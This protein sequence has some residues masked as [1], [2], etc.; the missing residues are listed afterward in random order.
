MNFP[1]DDRERNFSM[2]NFHLSYLFNGIFKHIYK[3]GERLEVSR[4]RRHGFNGWKNVKMPLWTGLTGANLWNLWHRTMISTDLRSLSLPLPS[5]FEVVDNCERTEKRCTTDFESKFHWNKRVLT[6]KKIQKLLHWQRTNQQNLSCLKASLFFGF[7]S[8]I[9][10]RKWKTVRPNKKRRSKVEIHRL[11][12]IRCN[13]KASKRS[14]NDYSSSLK[15]FLIDEFPQKNV[16]LRSDETRTH[17]FFHDLCP[18]SR[19]DWA[20]WRWR[21]FLQANSINS[22]CFELDWIWNWSRKPVEN[23]SRIFANSKSQFRFSVV[24]IS[25]FQ[26]DSQFVRFGFFIMRSTKEKL[27][28]KE[29]EHLPSTNRH[30]FHWRNSNKK[31]NEWNQADSKDAETWSQCRWAFPSF[32][33]EEICHF[34]SHFNFSRFRWT[35]LLLYQNKSKREF[36][37]QSRKRSILLPWREEMQRHWRSKTSNKEQFVIDFAYSGIFRLKIDESRV[38]CSSTFLLFILWTFFQILQSIFGQIVFC[39]WEKKRRT[40]V[41]TF[42]LVSN[43]KIEW[44]TLFRSVLLQRI[45]GRIFL[46]SRKVWFVGP[47]DSLCSVI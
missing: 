44:R 12:A 25:S 26:A 17:R 7:S 1:D 16:F 6:M 19:S 39:Q 41:I 15:S 38:R 35:F 18:F 33:M 45:V 8:D 34:S 21:E 43:S 32:S 23:I 36:A 37:H 13:W 28:K 3:D 47:I 30:N 11:L 29:E 5:L 9:S 31:L 20:E 10:I 14:F 40:I 42:A 22:Q 4:F 2:A 27:A 46:S 24:S